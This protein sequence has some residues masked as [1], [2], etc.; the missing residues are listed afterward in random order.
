MSDAQKAQIMRI[1]LCN[2]ENSLEILNLPLSFTLDDVKKQH[3]TLSLLTHPDK[4][5][6]DL[7]EQAKLAESALHAARDDLLEHYDLWRQRIAEAENNVQIEQSTK[8]TQLAHDQAKAIG[9]TIALQRLVVS[10]EDIKKKSDYHHWVVV[11]ITQQFVN[12]KYVQQQEYTRNQ[13]ILNKERQSEAEKRK[14]IEIAQVT[15][16]DADASI[17]QRAS[18]W[19]NFSKKQRFSGTKSKR[20]LLSQQN[21]NDNS[22]QEQTLV[23]LINHDETSAQPSIT[24]NEL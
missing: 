3:R 7:K 6:S 23:Q 5:T 11:E 2:Q 24:K 22:L 17:N 1:L 9:S 8:L 18:S 21:L 15:Q 14:K 16:N 20:R 19:R 4:V 10:K 12:K 13:E